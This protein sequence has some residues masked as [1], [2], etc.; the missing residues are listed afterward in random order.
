MSSESA[1]FV[2]HTNN[3]TF[4]GKKADIFADVEMFMNFNSL[5]INVCISLFFSCYISAHRIRHL[6]TGAE[7]IN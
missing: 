2:H 5:K 6:E 1:L 3:K 4:N 7:L